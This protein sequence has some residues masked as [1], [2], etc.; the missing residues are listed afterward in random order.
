MGSGEGEA[1]TGTGDTVARVALQQCWEM[2][3]IKRVRKS[4]G[5]SI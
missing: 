3:T 2:P 1:E 5:V 4:M